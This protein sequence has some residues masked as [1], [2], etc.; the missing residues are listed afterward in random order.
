FTQL[1]IGYQTN[2]KPSNAQNNKSTNSRPAARASLPLHIHNNLEPG[3]KSAPGAACTRA[4]ERAYTLASG[5]LSNALSKVF[6]K[7]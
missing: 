1:A 6:V 2:R 4:V 7:F 3:T 5:G